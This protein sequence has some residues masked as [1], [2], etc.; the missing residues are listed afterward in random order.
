MEAPRV[1]CILPTTDRPDF[2]AQAL[3][4]FQ[5][6]TY[7]SRELVVVDDGKEPVGHLLPDD[8]RVR[9]VRL[10]R[11]VT[12][13]A[14]LNVGVEAARGALIQKLDDDDYYAP[15]FLA[16]TVGALDGRAVGAVAACASFLVLLA[17]TGEVRHA[18]S[19]WFAGATLCF[20]RALWERRPFRDE[21]RAVD[22]F[23]LQDHAPQRVALRDPEL[24]MVV[25]HNH[26]H[27]WTHTGGESVEALF[28]RCALYRKPL[29]ALV[30]GEDLAFYDRLRRSRAA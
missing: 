23:F 19:G 2:V 11:P 15:G 18:G 30:P 28:R 17:E 8:P 13:G 21:R 26:G 3:R 20:H 1:S 14:K 29:R 25:R 10:D 6:Q 12:L 4:C 22:W 9:Y 7:G 24:F 5:R 16:A 27:T